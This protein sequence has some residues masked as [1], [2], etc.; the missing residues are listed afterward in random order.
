MDIHR[1]RIRLQVNESITNRPAVRAVVNQT[2]ACQSARNFWW[3][4]GRLFAG[5]QVGI[6]CQDGSPAD[7]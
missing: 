1:I 2:T 7:V 3:R 6:V 5:T 4:E